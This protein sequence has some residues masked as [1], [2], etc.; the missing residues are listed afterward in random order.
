MTEETLT[1]K[2]ME[3][4]LESLQEEYSNKVISIRPEK[5][6]DEFIEDSLLVQLKKLKE[7][8]VLDERESKILDSTIINVTQKTNELRGSRQLDPNSGD[9]KS[10]ILY[11][12][13]YVSDSFPVLN[14]MVESSWKR[15]IKKIQ[16]I[17]K[18]E[19]RNGSEQSHFTITTY[20]DSRETE[21]DKLTKLINGIE[22]GEVNQEFLYWEAT[23]AKRWERLCNSSR[24]YSMHK[25]SRQILESNIDKITKVIKAN[26]DNQVHNLVNLGTGGGY[27][28]HVILQNMIS[29]IKDDGTR[30]VYIPIDYST[31]M[32]QGSIEYVLKY[33][34]ENEKK[35]L[36]IKAILGD[37][38]KI[39]R[40]KH[41]IE[42]DDD[43]PNI[44]CCLGNTF[45]N[46]IEDRF[47]PLFQ[48][49][50]RQEDFLILGI[51][52]I[53]DRT[54]PELMEGYDDQNLRELVIYP[55]LEHISG[56]IRDRVNIGEV[57]KQPINLEVKENWNSIPHSKGVLTS[58]TIDNR[59]IRHFYSTKYNLDSLIDYFKKKNLEVLD[60]Y[61]D[62]KKLYAKLIIRKKRK[63]K[64][65]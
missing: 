59:K 2:K 12:K 18:K 39:K 4:I 17:G 5:T 14:D 21:M 28:D 19:Q 30:M 23:S 38:F 52:L 51:D 6:I 7:A 47:I 42:E 50:L 44:Y 25:I 13:K 53:G 31:S 9:T 43:R 8:E 58:V 34:T 26:S 56:D 37:F 60:Q 22:E 46:F 41:I 3:Q 45:G 36:K 33:L 63:L 61:L 29:S 48:D 11:L 35:K 24:S 32:L 40:F 27:K 16:G 1:K 15:G 65:E 20:Y 54:N 10:S 62:D 64:T 55:L 49:I 57:L